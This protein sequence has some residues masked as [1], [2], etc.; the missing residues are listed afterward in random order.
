MIQNNQ[1]LCK[2]CKHSFQTW[3]D[4]LSMAN[5]SYTLRCRLSYKEEVVE[6][7]WVVGHKVKPPEYERCSLAR[8]KYSSPER[9]INCSE[10]G[11]FWEPKHKRDLFKLIAKEHHV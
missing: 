3:Y 4:R 9:D 1:L 7:N 8:Y 5:P 2:D 10:E 11:R 6:K